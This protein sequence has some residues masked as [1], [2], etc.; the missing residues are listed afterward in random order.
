MLSPFS[1]GQLCDPMACGP[2]GS[3][4]PGDSPGKNARV[5]C[6]APFQSD[7]VERC[8]E[9]VEFPERWVM[10]HHGFGNWGEK[11]ANCGEGERF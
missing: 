9:F 2:P 5:G 10:T 7:A 8:N 1:H 3:S 4:V 6:H 11:A